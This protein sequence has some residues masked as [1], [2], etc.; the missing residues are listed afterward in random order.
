LDDLDAAILA[1]LQQDGRASLRQVARKLG[2]SVTTVS[3]RVRHLVRLRVLQ[4]FVPLVSVQRLTEMGRSPS[5]V[6]LFVRPRR[7]PRVELR[8]VAEAI[9]E[10]PQ[11][12]YVFELAG[13]RE[14]LALASTPSPAA[15]RELVDSLRRHPLIDGVR[16]L[17]IQRVHKERPN[18]PVGEPSVG[19]GRRGPVPLA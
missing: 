10:E 18:H 7:H 5:C 6:M 8:R 17:N 12:C 2:A 3:T 16:T 19:E 14:L 4:G 15:S 1:I 13:G 9:A 11:V